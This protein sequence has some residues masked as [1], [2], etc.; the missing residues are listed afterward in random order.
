MRIPQIAAVGAP[1]PVLRT[2]LSREW[3][4]R[5]AQQ[6]N[7]ARTKQRPNTHHSS[8][9][10]S[11]RCS[12]RLS[13]E[14]THFRFP[15]GVGQRTEFSGSAASNGRHFAARLEAGEIGTIAPGKWTAEPDVCFDR[16]VMHDVDGAFVVRAA[17]AI[18]GEIAQIATRG[19][20]R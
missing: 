18:S 19:K 20:N 8:P 16:R 11:H 4:S 9:S 1:L 15:L 3:Y 5:N 13:R 6:T 7:Q 17:L 2:R 14:R 10:C 12:L